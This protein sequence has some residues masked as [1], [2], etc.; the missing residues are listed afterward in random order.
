MSFNHDLVPDKNIFLYYYCFIHFSSIPSCTLDIHN[1]KRRAYRQDN[2]PAQGFQ[3]RNRGTS[4]FDLLFLG[5]GHRV[6]LYRTGIIPLVDH[7]DHAH[8]FPAINN[9]RFAYSRHN[10]PHIPGFMFFI[11]KKTDLDH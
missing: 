4:I 6:N 11:N 9:D 3:I 8:H 5:N 2:K 10:F 1:K 7:I